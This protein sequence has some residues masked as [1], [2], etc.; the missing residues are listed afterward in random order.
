MKPIILLHGAIGA[1]DQLQPLAD[2]LSAEGYNVYTLAFY[3]HGQT[4]FGTEKFGIPAFTD[5]LAEFIRLE[6]L[7]QPD[8][9]GYSMGGYVALTLAATRPELI[10]RIATLATK[11]AWS[12]ETAVKEAAMLNPASIKEKVP[13]FAAALQRRHGP[14][15]EALLVHTAAMMQDLGNEPLLTEEQL[16]SIQNKVRIGLGDKDNMVSVGETLDAFRALPNSSMFMLPETKHPIEQ[17]NLPLLYRVLIQYF[18]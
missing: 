17:A 3:G 16:S 18:G 14:A 6:Q 8:V 4:P 2:L 10:G 13:R 1:P 9:F 12:P 11:F 7:E 5:Q 15:W